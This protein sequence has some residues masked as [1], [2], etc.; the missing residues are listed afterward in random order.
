MDEAVTAVILAGGAGRRLGGAD[1]GLAMLDRRPLAAWC[2]DAIR[3][4]VE[5]M[6]IVANRNHD[7]YAQFAPVI[8]DAVPGHRGPLAGIAAALAVA[9]TPWLITLPVDS[10]RPP[11]D[12]VT[13]LCAKIGSAHAAVADDGV[14]RQPLFALYHRDLAMSAADALSHK[15]PVWQWQEAI[16]ATVVD[17]ADHAAHFVNLNSRRD[18]ADFAARHGQL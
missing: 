5:A 11:P 4:Q 3:V 17:F 12:L 16:G 1:K 9:E 7:S 18:F 13:R 14:R 2:I 15:L 6:L 10:P 8:A